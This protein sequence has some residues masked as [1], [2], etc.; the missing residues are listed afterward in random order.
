MRRPEPNR[1]GSPGAVADAGREPGQSPVC[2][3]KPTL[4]EADLA[5]ATGYPIWRSSQPDAIGLR[6]LLARPGMHVLLDRDADRLDA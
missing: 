3:G 4:E 1:Q 5:R 2:R 6:E